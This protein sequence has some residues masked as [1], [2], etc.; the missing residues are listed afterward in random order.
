MK[1]F[2]KNHPYITIIALSLTLLAIFLLIAF[3]IQLSSSR[4]IY[5]DQSDDQLAAEYLEKYPISA[6][7]PYIYA[8]YD[9]DY[10]YTEF[11]IDGGSFENCPTDFCLKIT[12]STNTG[13]DQ[14]KSLMKTKGYD[15]EKYTILP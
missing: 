3:S 13:L 10:H 12:D 15:L 11:R 6:I 2:L 9:Q 1:A 7:L 8:Q 4:P 14:I 5:S